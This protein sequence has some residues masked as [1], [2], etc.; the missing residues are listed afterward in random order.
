MI[1]QISRIKAV[2]Q[3]VRRLFFVSENLLTPLLPKD[4]Y[5]YDL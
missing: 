2:S 1:L 4:S 5:F 3:N